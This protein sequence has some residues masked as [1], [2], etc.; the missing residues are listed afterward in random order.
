MER[1]K[2]SECIEMSDEGIYLDIKV[3]PDSSSTEICGV[4]PWRNQVKI[5]V[6]E[7]AVHGEANKAL[8][9]LFADLLEISKKRINIVRGKTTK[10][11]RMY[12]GGVDKTELIDKIER[13]SEGH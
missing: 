4:N 11:K 12:F 7:T 9:R 10:N 1:E 13:M 3:S 6:K 8:V 5:S 2:L